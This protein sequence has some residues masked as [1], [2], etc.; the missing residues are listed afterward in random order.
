VLD[1]GGGFG[2][3]VDCGLEVV[4]ADEEDSV[5]LGAPPVTTVIIPVPLE[6]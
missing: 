2:D 1:G 3:A 6:M 5:G 4:E